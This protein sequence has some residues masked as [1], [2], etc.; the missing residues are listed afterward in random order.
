MWRAVFAVSVFGVLVVAGA[1]ADENADKAIKQLDENFAKVKSYTAKTETMTDVEFGP[2][3]TQKMKMVGTSEWMRKGEKTM[4]RSET[5]C[6]TTKAQDG[7]TTTSKSKITT[8]DDGT[9]IYVLTEEDGKQT[10]MKSHAN[11]TMYQPGGYF[12][13]LEGYYNIKL[14]DDM[15][16]DGHDC[17][18][19][20]LTMKPMEG[21]PPS[22]R[23]VICCWK[24]HGITLKS[25]SFDANGKL[26]S[27]SMTKD[28]KVNAS[29]E[30]S[31]FTFQ[32]PE[33]AQMMDMTGSQT[34]Q[35]A[36]DNAQAEDGGAKEE[37]PAQEEQPQ[38]EKPKKKG[39]GLPK[40]PKF[41]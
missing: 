26:T 4:M 19:F 38:E 9:Y 14:L 8:V 35:P 31:R 27:Q 13:Q 28:V 39:L 23:M 7:K 25:E 20:E 11:P 24:D 3:H 40:K 34:G 15:N 30:E 37:K 21:V 36:E 6:E 2:G 17:Y 18:A 41:P 32:V 1:A 12:A 29:I 16:V 5:G 22:G 10:V 33:G